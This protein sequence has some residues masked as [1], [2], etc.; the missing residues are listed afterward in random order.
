MG[1]RRSAPARPLGKCKAARARAACADT[2]AAD[3]RK[4]HSAAGSSRCCCCPD[5][6]DPSSA[7]LRAH[8]AIGARLRGCARCCVNKLIAKVATPVAMRRKGAV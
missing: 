5:T 4:A 3:A 6:T 8:Q 7:C 2:C 1:C